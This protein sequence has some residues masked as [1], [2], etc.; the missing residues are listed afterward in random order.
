MNRVRIL[1]AAI[2]LLSFV[3]CS[4]KSTEPELKGSLT[5]KVTIDGQGVDGVIIDVSAFQI[6]GDQGNGKIFKAIEITEAGDYSIELSAGIYRADFAYYGFGDENLS[7]ARYPIVIS[8]DAKTV[9][10]V[11]LK[12][13]IPHSFLVIDGNAAVELS[14]E[15]SYHALNYR[16]YRANSSEYDFQMIAQVDTVSGTV[17]HTDYPPAIGD[18]YYFVSSIY[19]DGNESGYE[20]I[21][22]ISFTGSI[23]PPTGLVALDL[24]DYVRLNWDECERAHYYRIYRSRQNNNSWIVIDSTSGDSYYDN[25]PDTAL[26]YYRLTAVSTYGTESAPGTAVSVN[27]DG[28][29]DP[30]QELTIVDRGS[31]LYLSW[32]EYENVHHYSVYRSTG[33]A[34]DFRLINTT[35][36]NYYNDV[37][38]DIGTY[39][40][41]V[42]ASA[43]NDIESEPSA[44]VHA[45]YDGLLDFPAGFVAIN[46]G[47]R[48]ELGWEVV[49]WA[50]AYLIFRSTDGEIYI[51]VARV[52][53]NVTSY[54]DSPIYANLYYY[55]I[56]SETVTG[57]LG[58]LSDPVEVQYTANLIAPTGVVAENLGT[59]IRISWDLHENADG[60]KLYRA[61]SENDSYEYIDSTLETSYIDVPS[62]GG[63]Y[64]YKVRAFDFL[65]HQSPLSNS[66]YVHF[67]DRP[68]PPYDV[69]VVDSLY[70]VYLWWESIE[71]EAEYA[72]YR[73]ITMEG[74]Y[75]YI[76]TVDGLSAFD[77]PG[78]A[79]SYFYKIRTIVEYDTSDY[80][81]FRHVVFSGIL[82]PPSDLA[83]IDVGTHIHITWT[84]PDGASYYEVYRSD[85]VNGEYARIMTVY[86]DNADDAPETAGTYFFKI[87]AFTQGNLP[88]QFSN[89]VEVEFAP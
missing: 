70:K 4:E 19:G 47:L 64:Y 39:Y 84:A 2:I 74:G 67:D 5:G 86:E 10:D 71:T 6:S 21:R 78:S 3:S 18:Y 13:P 82:Q 27:F 35:S 60:Y 63:S 45:N 46:R 79:G 17:Y 53:G 22:P 59:S 66:A 36:N 48:V 68:L 83:A 73:S 15:S 8:P 32:L 87:K 23:R 11:E 50:G 57:T 30:P 16:L 62:T 38:I 31:S 81:E 1:F 12:D 34:G 58:E 7:T 20:G 69:I 61:R 49:P 41:Y 51:E 75:A 33:Q 44:T 56:A 52:A 89:S 88:S 43:T 40:Y 80:S 72:I 77:W 37:P 24:V 29:F 54:D 14:W 25:P 65:G 85:T 42:T 28:R 55:R 76:Q 26:Y 9:V